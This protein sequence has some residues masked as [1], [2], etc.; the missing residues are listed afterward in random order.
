MINDKLVMN[1]LSSV[2]GC[3]FHVNEKRVAD[4]VDWERQVFLYIY[5]FPERVKVLTPTTMPEQRERACFASLPLE[6]VG[7]IIAYVYEPV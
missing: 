1:A 6:T 7:R 5:I 3:T 4:W 2:S